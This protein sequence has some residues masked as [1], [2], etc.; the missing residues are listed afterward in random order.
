MPDAYRGAAEGRIESTAHA[1]P[2]YVCNETRACSVLIVVT[3]DRTTPIGKMINSYLNGDSDSEDH[4]I[5]LLF[6]ANRWEAA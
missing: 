6:S 5:H 1:I 2:W 3:A 4:V